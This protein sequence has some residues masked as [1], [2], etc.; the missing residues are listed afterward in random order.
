MKEITYLIYIVLYE[1]FIVGGCAYIVFWQGNSGWWWL[2]AC[3]MSGAAYR[4]Q[5]WIH[6]KYFTKKEIS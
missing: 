5:A 2:L 1:A 6:G 3:A 4:P